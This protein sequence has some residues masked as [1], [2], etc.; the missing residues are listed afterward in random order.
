MHSAAGER[1]PNPDLG[2]LRIPL[3]PL[4]AP[5]GAVAFPCGG[6]GGDLCA[7]E[8]IGAPAG[9]FR[10]HLWSATPKSAPIAQTCTRGSA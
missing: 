1:A 10:V 8:T 4:N 3:M 7:P 9:G 6:S 5:A 2:E